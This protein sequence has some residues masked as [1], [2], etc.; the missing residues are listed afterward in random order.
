MANNTASIK[1]V[2]NILIVD[3]IPANLKVLG[4]ILKTD[5]YKVR[6]VPSGSMAL[7]VAEKEKPDLILLDIMMP[8]MNGYEVCQQLKENPKLADIPVIF[9]SAL[10]DTNDIVK[11]LTS[12]GVDYITKPFQAEEV[13]ARV[14]THLKIKQQSMELQRLNVDKDRFLALLAHDLKNPFNAILGL[15]ELLLKNIRKY[16]INEIEKFVSNVNKVSQNT[17]NLLDNLLLWA[18][19]QSGKLPF[20]PQKLLFSEVFSE[21]LETLKPNADAKNILINNVTAK[22]VIFFAD[23]NMVKTVLRN[24]VSN[25]IKFTKSGDRIDVIAIKT[26]DYVTITVADTGVGITPEIKANLFDITHIQSLRGTANETGTGLGLFL[27]KEFVEKHNGKI[28]VESEVGNGTQFHFTL[29][30]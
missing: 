16:D 27:C 17:Y 22:D 13:K 6:P 21:I 9:I 3:D 14:S 25:A 4:D 30:N 29:S 28:W 10:N 8:D 26:D 15:L 12:G 24:L 1:A 7:Q 5:G 20:E 2:A 19:V 18:R 11:A 23:G